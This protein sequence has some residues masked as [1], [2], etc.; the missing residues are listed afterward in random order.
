MERKSHSPMNEFMVR[1]CPKCGNALLNFAPPGFCEHCGFHILAA[2]TLVSTPRGSQQK[3]GFWPAGLGPWEFGALMVAVAVRIVGGSFFQAF[4]ALVVVIV[5]GIVSKEFW[6]RA[7]RPAGR[8][9]RDEGVVGVS[10]S[11][12]VRFLKPILFGKRGKEQ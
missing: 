5:I 6:S 10:E 9:L 1:Y 4:V 3:R 12:Y 8:K 7:V 11:L 2:P